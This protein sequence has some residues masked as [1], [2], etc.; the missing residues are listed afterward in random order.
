MPARAA[1]K[2]ALLSLW[3]LFNGSE[4]HNTLGWDPGGVSDPCL[5]RWYGVGCEDPCDLYLDGEECYYGRIVSINL[6]NNNL[7][8][9]LSDWTAIERSTIYRIS[10]Y[11]TT[12]SMERSHPRLPTRPWSIS[13]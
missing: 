1:D 2:A 3:T 6:A 5:H 4:W 10:I 12:T 11:P 9:R 8:G 7:T 13:T